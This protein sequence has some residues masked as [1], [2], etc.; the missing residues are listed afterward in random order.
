MASNPGQTTI[1]DMNVDVDNLYREDTY[2]DGR[3]ASIRCLTPVTVDGD[4]D[5][6]RTPQFIGDTTLM[7]GMKV[8]TSTKANIGR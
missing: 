3:A 7:T 4:I 6:S 8:R 5:T 1:D 2:T